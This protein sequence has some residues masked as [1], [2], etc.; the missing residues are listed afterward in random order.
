[1]L[2][3]TRTI[4]FSTQLIHPPINLE[5]NKDSIK[6][7][8][9]ELSSVKVCN[10]D[11][12]SFDGFP[13]SPPRLTKKRD[14]TVSS[15][16]FSRDH[17]L[18]EEDWADITLENFSE[19]IK[20]ILNKAFQ[21]LN[22]TFLV[23][24]VCTVR[25]L[26]TPGCSTDA[27]VFLAEKACGLEGGKIS[28][29]FK[30]PAQMFGMRLLFPPLKDIPYSFDI[31]IESFNRDPRQIFVE[32]KGTFPLIHPIT[33]TNVEVAGVNMTTTYGLCTNEIKNFLDQFD[34]SEGGIR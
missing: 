17:I 32:T 7:I 2:G 18:I 29:Y 26:F 11:N 27:R 4:Y 3:E 12:I 21:L 34:T 22:L 8:Y 33:P 1:M 16:L 30:R 9:H 6:N 28:P 5:G 14:S 31:R 24:Q 19:K 25:C 13:T 20:E 15:C 10:Y 23:I